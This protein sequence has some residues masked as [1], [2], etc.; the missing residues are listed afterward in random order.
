MNT[1]NYPVGDFLT[2]VKNAVMAN[3][4]IVVLRKTNLIKSVADAMLRLGYFSNLKTEK[5]KI[6]V[7][8]SRKNKDFVIT[9]I[10]LVS[11]PGLRV[12]K[13]VE[14]L[15]KH[16]RPSILLI[17]TPKGVLSSKEAIGKRAGGEVLAEIY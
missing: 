8:M 12:Y 15:E 1:T 5:N 3:K 14:E 17:S 2:R 6:E 4:K 9:S 11:R 16:K 7:T 13:S 10:K